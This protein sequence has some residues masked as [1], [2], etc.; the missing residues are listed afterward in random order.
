[1]RMSRLTNGCGLELS[2]HLLETT[3][4]KHT[5]NEIEELKSKKSMDVFEVESCVRGH[6]I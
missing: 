1:M 2:E 4:G 6:H 3:T 5:A